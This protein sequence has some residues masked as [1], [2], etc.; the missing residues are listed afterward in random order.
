MWGLSLCEYFAFM[1]LFRFIRNEIHL[2]FM[3]FCMSKNFYTYFLF[4]KEYLFFF[5]TTSDGISD[6]WV[7]RQK[8]KASI[9]EGSSFCLR[10]KWR[11]DHRNWLQQ[12]MAQH[13]REHV[14]NVDIRDKKRG[15]E[16]EGKGIQKHPQQ[17]WLDLAPNLVENSQNNLGMLDS[18]LI[19]WDLNNKVWYKVADLI[20]RTSQREKK[21]Y[22]NICF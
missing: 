1:Q 17:M 11:H 15:K 13:S 18:I 4:H 5:L 20:Y 3:L 2:F 6:S 10:E 12:D 8:N 21:V 16:D 14:G 19:P 7:H 22:V 9:W